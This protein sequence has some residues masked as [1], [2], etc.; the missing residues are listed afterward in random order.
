MYWGPDGA[1]C[2]SWSMPS[3][4]PTDAQLMQVAAEAIKSATAKQA[5]ACRLLDAGG[6][7]STV[8]ALAA[9]AMEELGKSFVCSTLLSQPPEVR[10]QVGTRW[11]SDHR[12]KL[13]IAFA[14]V[15]LFV[16]EDE[17]PDNLAV[18]TD[19]AVTV[20]AAV[21]NVK[22]R[23]LYVDAS[24][25]GASIL[26]SEVTES[27]ARALVDL[28]GSAI[29]TLTSQGLTLDGT[30]DPAAYR[31]FMDRMNQSP[32]RATV[33]LLAAEDPMLV[34]EQFRGAVRGQGPVPEWLLAMLP[35]DADT[36]E[37]K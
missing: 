21:N 6:D 14:M 31:A 4:A 37:A 24:T 36:P 22:F 19:Q 28:V 11:F 2:D 3:Y 30:E 32:E 25:D 27:D 16:D 13:T 5:D 34:L 9:F 29:D 12:L 15:R 8:F 23:A 35:S 18:F 20:S 33:E 1:Q 10:A 7:P 26:T 17:L